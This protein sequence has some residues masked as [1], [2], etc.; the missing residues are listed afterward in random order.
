MKMNDMKEQQQQEERDIVQQL[1]QAKLESVFQEVALLARTTALKPDEIDG[2]IIGA[3]Q[4]FTAKLAV[5]S[6]QTL[7]A[8]IGEMKESF[9]TFRDDTNDAV[10]KIVDA[11]E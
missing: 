9:E 10:D 1:T 3:F 7:D 4:D 5:E 2:T 8:F 11:N 6:D